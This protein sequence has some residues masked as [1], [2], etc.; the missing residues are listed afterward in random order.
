MASINHDP[1]SGLNENIARK[2][3]LKVDSSRQNNILRI[4][5]R[6]AKVKKR[7]KKTI[8]FFC[9]GKF[10]MRPFCRYINCHGI[11][12]SLRLRCIRTVINAA[13]KAGDCQKSRDIKM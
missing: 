10:S 12:N 9:I 5:A 7:K 8:I 3:T 11:K 6:K 4:K 1:V 2:Q 13:V